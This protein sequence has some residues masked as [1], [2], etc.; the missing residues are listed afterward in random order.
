[1]LYT[2]LLYNA[3]PIHCTP[4]PLH[5]PVMNTQQISHLEPGAASH[6]RPWEIR[7]RVK[8]RDPPDVQYPLRLWPGFS[9]LFVRASGVRPAFESSTWNKWAQPL[10][11]LN[12]QRIYIHTYV[13]VCILYEQ[14]QCFWGARPPPWQTV[15]RIMRTDRTHLNACL[16]LNVLSRLS[17]A[18]VRLN[19]TFV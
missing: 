12:F 2:S 18:I 15:D 6:G 5:P 4:L 1:M 7:R 16:P 11:D 8:R 10:R 14:K 19:N 3:T 9:R 17:S 13:Y